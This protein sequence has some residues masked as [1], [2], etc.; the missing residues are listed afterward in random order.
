MILGVVFLGMGAL[1]LWLG[2]FMSDIKSPGF[3]GGFRQMAAGTQQALQTMKTMAP[4][5]TN[6]LRQFGRPAIAT[7]VAVNTTGMEINFTQMASV[8][9]LVTLDGHSP[10]PVSITMPL[11]N[12][13][14]LGIVKGGA[15]KV[16]VDPD[17]QMSVLIEGPAPVSSGGS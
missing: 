11:H 2:T 1:Y 8:D 7:V 9:L 6:R 16:L 15:L 4:D 13:A 14:G 3:R 5:N 10:Y 17:D 12:V